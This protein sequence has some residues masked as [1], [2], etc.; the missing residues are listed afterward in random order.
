M[1]RRVAVDD[2]VKNLPAPVRTHPR[3]TSLDIHGHLRRLILDGTL[4][5]GTEL[6]Q[7]ELAR[8]FDV[9]RTPLR[10]A[11]RMLQEE[12]LIE[13]DVNARGRVT[14][15]DAD[16]LDALYAARIML[17]GLGVR[18]TAGR[19]TRGEAQD[20]SAQ[21][22]DMD[23]ALQDEDPAA[24]FDAHRRFHR[25]LTS[26][27]GALL[28]RSM[29]SYAERSERYMRARQLSHPDSFEQGRKE[30]YE[31]FVAVLGGDG[32]RASRLAA[33]HLSRTA[34]SVM[35]DYAPGHHAYA[36]HS[37]LAM[38]YGPAEDPDPAGG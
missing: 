35:A 29:A 3:R 34:L 15:F 18:I 1:P 22:H 20:A 12:G 36:V 26:R 14:G 37:A 28:L 32:E 13:A 33:G 19:L 7:T 38:V 16:E 30:H 6:K 27:S 24:W 4:P 31:L 23:R 25:L 8:M 2:L 9:S 5:P 11:F 17:D 21:L 10:E